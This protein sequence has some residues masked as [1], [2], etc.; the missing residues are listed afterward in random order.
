MRLEFFEPNIPENLR[1]QDWKAVH[2][3]RFLF[4]GKEILLPDDIYQVQEIGNRLL[5]LISP[6]SP[7]Y[8]LGSS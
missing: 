7:I 4:N 6:R 5:I 8:T 2:D 3:K 1:D